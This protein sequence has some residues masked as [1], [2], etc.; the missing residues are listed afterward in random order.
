MPA[1]SDMFKNM[2]YTIPNNSKSPEYVQSLTGNKINRD[3]FIHN[4][5]KD[6]NVTIIEILK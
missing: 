6:I 3:T 1:T 4:N 5:I 2:N